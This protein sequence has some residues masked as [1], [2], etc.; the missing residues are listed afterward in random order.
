MAC[1]VEEMWRDIKNVV[2]EH[3]SRGDLDD[4]TLSE[5]LGRAV[6]RDYKVG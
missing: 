1:D 3:V 6:S 4:Y 5:Y 2:I